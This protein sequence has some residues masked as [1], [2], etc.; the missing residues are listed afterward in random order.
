MFLKLLNAGHMVPL[1]LPQQSLE[2][3]STFIFGESFDQSPQNM[4]AQDKEDSCPVCPSLT[5][6]ECQ[7]CPLPDPTPKTGDAP[8]SSPPA[9]ASYFQQAS[10]AGNIPWLITG[11]AVFSLIVVS[12]RSRQQP[13][14]QELV[15]D[16]D[17]ELR[18][19]S[20]SDAHDSKA[21]RG[22]I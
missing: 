12:I 16:Y 11:L 8:S 10:S 4:L 18:E 17:L 19:G 9:A 1:D 13:R 5:C 21:D 7:E 3:M 22:I 14:H 20:Y 2:M 15:S 6:E